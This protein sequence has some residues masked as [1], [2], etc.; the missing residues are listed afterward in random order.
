MRTNTYPPLEIRV[1]Q[2]ARILAK[3]S[4]DNYGSETEEFLSM[5]FDG[6][7]EA[8]DIAAMGGSIHPIYAIF[9]QKAQYGL[10]DND[11]PIEPR[12]TPMGDPTPLNELF[13][14]YAIF[15]E[16]TSNEA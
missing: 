10:R 8:Y 4:R 7:S 16:E 13:Q 3:R 14:K 5:L 11:R 12:D 9:T 2:G 1:L 6:F 15:E